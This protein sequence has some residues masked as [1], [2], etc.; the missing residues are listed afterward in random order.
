M[1]AINGS[2]FSIETLMT[3]AAIGA[4]FI[5]AAIVVERG[6]GDGQN[7]GE[8]LFHRR[9]FQELCAFLAMRNSDTCR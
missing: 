6:R 1:G 8:G 7:A 4:V 5:N 2:P 3:V 9:S